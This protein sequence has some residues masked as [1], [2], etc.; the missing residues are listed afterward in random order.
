MEYKADKYINFCIDYDKIREGNQEAFRLLFEYYYPKIKAL[1]YRFVDN[2]IAED[3]TQDLF[4]S[5]WIHR[6]KIQPENIGSFLFKSIQNR[7]INHLKH[8]AVANNY[9]AYLTIAQQ[10]IEYLNQIH[11]NQVWS[12]VNNQNLKEVIKTAV[13]QLPPKCAEAFIKAYFQDMSNKEIAD[14]MSISVRTAET[15]IY[16]AL[17]LLRDILKDITL[18]IVILCNY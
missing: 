10:R 5:L 18:L 6:Q 1:A 8:N 13:H 9:N 3:L 16:K 17:T 2:E 12:Y 11:D 14:S 15:H 7:C 4:T